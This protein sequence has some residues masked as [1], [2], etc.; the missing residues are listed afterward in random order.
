MGSGVGSNTDNYTKEGSRMNDRY[1][2]RMEWYNCVKP[3]SWT[4]TAIEAFGT[5]EE[6]RACIKGVL[7]NIGFFHSKP[8][9]SRF[10]IMDV[11][12]GKEVE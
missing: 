5:L 10:Y 4:I 8:E 6:A 12:E 7:W 9:S 2:V 3:D 1:Q 11:V